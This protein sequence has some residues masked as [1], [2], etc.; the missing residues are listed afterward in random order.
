M[1]RDAR[2]ERAVPV[3]IMSLGDFEGGGLWVEGDSGMGPALR[4]LPDGST[5]SGWVHDIHNKPFSF[6]G[7]RWHCTEPWCG[8]DRWV[9]AAYVPRGGCQV[10]KNYFRELG[11]LGFPVEDLDHEPNEGQESSSKFKEAGVSLASV[12]LSNF[13]EG[14]QSVNEELHGSREL[15][16]VLPS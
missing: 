12:S 5:R 1:H 8:Q 3:W 14:L 6:S 4:V 15:G 10:A 9:I 11:D 7:L 13:V 16:G 2:N